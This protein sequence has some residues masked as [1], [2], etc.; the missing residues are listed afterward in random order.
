[1]TAGALRHCLLEFKLR[2]KKSVASRRNPVRF[3]VPSRVPFPVLCS[4]TIRFSFTLLL[5]LASFQALLL[6][7]ILSTVRFLFTCYDFFFT[8]YHV[9]FFTLLRC[10]VIYFYFV[11]PA[12][13]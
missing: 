12:L 3:S 10:C 9:S 4:V 11:T 13:V 7:S 5:L 2:M 6:L 1:M 8:F